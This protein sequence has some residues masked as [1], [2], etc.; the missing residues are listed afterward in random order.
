MVKNT[1]VCVSPS[2]GK[3]KVDKHAYKTQD[4]SQTVSEEAV[5]SAELAVVDRMV[6]VGTT[7]AKSIII[8]MK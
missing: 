3:T 6:P 2:E 8:I 1:N 7:C 4:H 5:G